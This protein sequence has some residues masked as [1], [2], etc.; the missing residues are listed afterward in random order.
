MDELQL[1]RDFFGEPS[2]PDPDM[3]AAAKARM[4]AGG[5]AVRRRS[6]KRPRPGRRRGLL[7]RLGI[8]AVAATAAAV[9]AAVAVAP[10]PAVR[11]PAAVGPAPAVSH[12]AGGIAIF[13]LPGGAAVG[14]SV[15]SGREILLTAA[16]TAA[17][18]AQ[19]APERYYV[20]PGIVGNFVRVGPP[21]K[22]L[23][24]P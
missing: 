20:T 18:A 6:G 10:G 2:P 12:G 11:K 1:V 17:K 4:S 24:G 7:L 15:G 21:G 8:P 22:P 13:Q 16:R 14:G 9:V 19:P 5:P 3:V 23:P